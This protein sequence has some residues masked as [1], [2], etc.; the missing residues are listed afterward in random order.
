MHTAPHP[1]EE[2]D[3]R[4]YLAMLWRYRI[5]IL[6]VGA[7]LGVFAGINGMTANAMYE[8]E[9]PIEVSRPKVTDT[10]NDNTAVANFIPI[11]A[12]RNVAAQVIKELSLDKP[13]YNLSA[14]SFFGSV[15]TVE[16]VKNSTILVLHGYLSD[17]QMLAKMLNRV[18]QLASDAARAA[19][20]QEAEQIRDDIKLQLD[21]SRKRMEDAEKRAREEREKSQIELLKRDVEA[22]LTE[23]GGL[24]KLQLELERE[25]AQLA[26]AQQELATRDKVETV[27]RTI[28]TDPLILESSR[29]SGVAPRDLIGMSFKSEVVNGVYSLLDEE[30]A[31]R[32][33]TVAGLEKQRAQMAARSLDG[34]ELKSLNRLYEAEIKISRLEMELELSRKVYQEVETSYEKSRLTVAARSSALQILDPAVPPDRPM[35][36]HVLRYA[37]LAFLFGVMAASFVFILRHAVMTP[38]S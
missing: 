9:I 5:P 3:V 37:A 33:A 15:V 26:K 18:A 30:V 36:R 4:E 35:A 25:R 22:Q 27:R 1:P 8:A 23:R 16:E 2:I 10:G 20:R 17:P 24:L 28:D 13:P 34:P 14:T 21:D 12:N 32:S 38:S 6:I 29:A 19:N 31:K 7:V 11:I